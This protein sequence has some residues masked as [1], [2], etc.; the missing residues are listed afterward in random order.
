MT[1]EFADHS[2]VSG[3]NLADIPLAEIGRE[4][5]ARAQIFELRVRVD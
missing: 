1:I 3:A 2:I 5:L 4:P